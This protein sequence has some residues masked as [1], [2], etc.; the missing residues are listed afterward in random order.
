MGILNIGEAKRLVG[1]KPARHIAPHRHVRTFG[2]GGSIPAALMNGGNGYGGFQAGKINRLTLDFIGRNAS[3]D[4]DLLQDNRQ[5]RA[6]SRMLAINNPYFKKFLAMA[7]QNI[8]GPAGILMKSKVTNENGKETAETKYIN[9]RIDE[10]WHIQGRKG[11]CTADGKFSW[12]ASQH[13][14][15]KNSAREGENVTKFVYGRQFNETG[16]AL[17]FLDNDQ[18]DDTYNTTLPDGGAIRMGVEVDQYAKPRAYHLWTYHPFDPMSGIRERKRIPAENIVHSAIWERPGQ[19]R[20]YTWASA[21]IV[22][23]NQEKGWSEATLV[24]A[25]ASAAKFATIESAVADGFDSD[26]EDYEGEA[27]NSDGT[28]YMGGNDGEILS[29]DPGQTLNFTDP[30][31]PTNTFKEFQI[32]MVREMAT[33]LLVS[34]PTLGN[35]LEGVNFSSIRAGLLDERDCWRV[36][37]R[38]FIEDFCE[39]IRR[40]WLRMALLTTLTDISLTPQQMEQV[41]WKPRGW[42]WV[43]PQKDANATVLQLGNCLTTYANELGRKGLDFEETVRERARE[44]KF[45]ESMQEEFELRAP[46]VLATDLAGDSAGKGIVGGDATQEA[47]EVEGGKDGANNE[48]SDNASSSSSSGKTAKKAGKK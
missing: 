39:P 13:L 12:V 16:F 1:Y 30:R 32:S 9:K 45:I 2:D 19:T 24:A 35:D 38:W 6:R 48:T 3:A 25:R 15:I 26:D 8:V 31:F 41:A 43:D 21:A 11:R 40:A 27:T 42:D 29:L 23:M 5:M 47:E 14:A 4:Q 37:Q 46:L 18:L 22:A 20:G 36:L 28:Q 44:Q 34:Y 10:E 17:Q 33:A 7:A